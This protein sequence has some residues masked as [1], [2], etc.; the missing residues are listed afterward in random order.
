MELPQK[1][2][3]FAKPGPLDTSPGPPPTS[4][5]PHPKHSYFNFSI[6]KANLLPNNGHKFNLKNC[7]YFFY[8]HTNPNFHL[9]Y[10]THTLIDDLSDDQQSKHILQRLSSEIFPDLICKIA[11]PLSMFLQT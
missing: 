7:Q 9:T 5:P 10:D 8:N 3:S 4:L 11:K 1:S 6:F 2:V